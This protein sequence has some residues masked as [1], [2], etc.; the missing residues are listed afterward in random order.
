MNEAVRHWTTRVV[1]GQVGD[2]MDAIYIAPGRW[3]CEKER[4]VSLTG[5]PREIVRSDEAVA[6]SRFRDVRAL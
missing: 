4:V 1:R 5:K 2:R 6:C 3:W